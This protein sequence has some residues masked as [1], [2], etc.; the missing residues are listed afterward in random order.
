MVDDAVACQNTLTP[1]RILLARAHRSGLRFAGAQL[2]PGRRL[3]GLHDPAVEARQHGN[4]DCA[5]G[6]VGGTV[7]SRFASAVGAGVPSEPV[8][9]ACLFVE[10]VAC[11]RSCL[12]PS[13]M[14]AI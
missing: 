8:R 6:M 11:L 7:V 12:A 10:N 4:R 9:R 13:F 2:P 14:L 5:R 1:T 3:L